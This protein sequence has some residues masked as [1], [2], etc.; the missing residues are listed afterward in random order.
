MAG[1]LDPVFGE[2]GFESELGASV[3]KGPS[4][5]N[6]LT[7]EFHSESEH[8]INDKRFDLELQVYHTVPIADAGNSNTNQESAAD[9]DSTA[10]GRRRN[11]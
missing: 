7:F 10:E 6:G 3:F 9:A 5:W 2:S 8:T 1:Y 11:L 4:K